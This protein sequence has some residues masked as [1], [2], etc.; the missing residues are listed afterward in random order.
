MHNVTSSSR[1]PHLFETL[2]F[3]ET[4][5][6]VSLASGLPDQYRIPFHAIFAGASAIGLGLLAY[7]LRS[8]DTTSGEDDRVNSKLE[9]TDLLEGGDPDNVLE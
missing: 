2:I 6:W 5:F 1:V 4:A 9:R 8:A 7:T 3:T